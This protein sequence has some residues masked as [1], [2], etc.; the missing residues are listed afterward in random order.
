VG[1]DFEQ[2]EFEHLKQADRTG[3]NDDGIGFDSAARPRFRCS[4]HGFSMLS[5]KILAYPLNV[6]NTE[7]NEK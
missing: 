6:V 3:T 2:A 1:F 5:G 4:L 7:L